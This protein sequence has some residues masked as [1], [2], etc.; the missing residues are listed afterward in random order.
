ML[1]NWEIYRKLLW[2]TSHQCLHTGP[3][4]IQMIPVCPQVLC[5]GTL[6]FAQVYIHHPISLPYV[7]VHK[8]TAL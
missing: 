7:Y 3:A 6:K 8:N 4:I 1:E 5:L 2:Q